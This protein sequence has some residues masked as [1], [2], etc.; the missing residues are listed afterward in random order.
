MVEIKRETSLS[1][2]CRFGFGVGGNQKSNYLDQ[3]RQRNSPTIYLVG[4]SICFDMFWP[5]RLNHIIESFG[6]FA[7]WPR[8]LVEILFGQRMTSTSEVLVK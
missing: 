7:A 2:D 8:S 3:S 4:S 5:V 1:F 6:L